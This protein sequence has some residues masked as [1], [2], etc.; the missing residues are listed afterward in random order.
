MS[1]GTRNQRLGRAL[2][3]CSPGGAPARPRPR[4]ATERQLVARFC[5]ARLRR[6][7]RCPV[8]GRVLRQPGPAGRSLETFDTPT[9]E[10]FR[11]YGSADE[12]L[13]RDFTRCGNRRADECESCSRLY[14]ADTFQLIRAGVAG[15]KRPRDGGDNPLVFA[16]LTAPSFGPCTAPAERRRCRPRHDTGQPL[17]PR[18]PDGLHAVHGDGDPTVGQPLCADC[19]DYPSQVVWQWWAPELW[20]RFTITLRRAPRPPPR[21]HPSSARRGG[22]PAVRQGR[23]VP[24]ARR[25]PLPRPGPPRRPADAR[26]VR[27]GPGRGHRRGAGRPGRAG[28]HRRAVHRPPGPRR[29][30][31]PVLAFGAQVDTRPVHTDRRTDDPDRSLTPEQVAGYLAKYATKR[32]RR[33]RA[34]TTPTCAGWRPPPGTSPPVR[35]P[36]TRWDAPYGLLGKWAHTLGFRGHFATKSRRYSLTLGQLRR[37]RQRAQ[38]RIAEANRVGTRID[39]RQ[40]EAELLA[41]DADETTV[42]IGSWVYAGSGWANGGETALAVA[43]AA[44]AREHAQ[45]RAQRRRRRT[46]G[47]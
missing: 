42:V 20:R 30:P 28:G 29:R 23:G 36:P 10:L 35:P 9:G 44:R 7:V 12:P 2:R 11:S 19:Y 5:L 13:G 15:G 3:P 25:R 17:P 37:A 4:R 38:A 26:R 8:P 46:V 39:L 22:E 40:L 45:E 47:E 18:T 43:A 14:A 31:G 16:T 41:D 21:H 33:H 34:R 24:A 32:H 27:P 1:P 6:L